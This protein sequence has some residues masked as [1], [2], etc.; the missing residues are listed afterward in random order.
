MSAL[1]LLQAARKRFRRPKAGIP[2]FAKRRFCSTDATEDEYG[3]MNASGETYKFDS[4]RLESGKII[5]NAQIRYKT[6]GELNKAGDNCVVICHA[7]TGNAS[8]D[9]WWAPLLGPNK[10]FDTNKYMVFCANILGSCYGSTGPRSTNPDTG[11]RYGSSFPAVTVRDSVR[12]HSQVLKSL[13]V[14][15]IQF[16]LGGSLGGMQALEWGFLEGSDWV[17]S[18]VAIACGAK[19]TAWQIAISEVQRGAILRD[20]TWENGQGQAHNG[21]GIARQIAMISYRSHNAYESKF[22]RKLTKSSDFEDVNQAIVKGVTP[23][24]D[25]EGYLQYQ[26]SKFRSRFDAA[27]YVACTR[28]MDTHD[29]GRGRGGIETALGSLTQPTLVIGFDGDLLYPMKEQLELAHHIP[30]STMKEMTSD[31]GHDAFLLE[32]DAIQNACESFFVENDIKPP[33]ESS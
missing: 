11:M 25:V 16:V 15:Q 4:L 21:L 33:S 10:L 27:S 17:K 9:E 13:G 20:P 30:N 26:D 23:T 1:R 32:Y 28:K 2:F 18:V 24:F 6:F 19:H 5:K 29:V 3:T 31:A 8:V 7:L 14:N 12:S 22:G